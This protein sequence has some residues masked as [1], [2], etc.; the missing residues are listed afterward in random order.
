MLTDC[1]PFIKI[2]KTARERLLAQQGDF[3]LL[4]NPQLRLVVQSGADRRRE[5]LLT[6]TELAGIIP[7]EFEDASRRDLILAVREPGYGRPFHHVPAI[8]AAYAPLHYV[9]LFLRGEHG[10]RYGLQLR[11]RHG[12]RQRTRLEQRVFYRFR[13]HPRSHEQSPLFYAGRLFQQYLV[14]IFVACEAANL[15]WIRNH[16]V[17]IR[18]DVYYGLQ[19]SLIRED[20]DAASVGRRFILPASFTGSDRFMQQLFQDSM[21][22]VRVFGK[23]TFF[24]T[25]TA[26]PRWKEITD[27]LLPG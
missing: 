7:D 20:I 5:N 10:W 12:T 11:D 9:L 2:Y 4:L 18:A 15:Q 23:P 13:L 27:E 6:A 8:H 21:A 24:I 26:N 1:N 16:Q 25:F 19:D 14:D 22:V 17:N 3:R